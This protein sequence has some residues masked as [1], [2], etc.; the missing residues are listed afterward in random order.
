[1]QI[2]RFFALQRGQVGQFLSPRV[3]VVRTPFRPSPGDIC[4]FGFDRLRQAQKFANYLADLG[5]TFQ[6]RRSQ[7]MP[8]SYEIRLA[9]HSDLAR[10][11]AHWDRVDQRQITLPAQPA[12]VA[13]A[14]AA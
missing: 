1:M 12:S 2:G 4:Y 9:G 7:V 6:I 13:S 14:Q 10:T 8:Q 3:L 5:Y 11:L